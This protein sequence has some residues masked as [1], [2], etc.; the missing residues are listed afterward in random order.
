MDR[1]LNGSDSFLTFRHDDALSQFEAFK[2]EFPL[3]QKS[4]D[5]S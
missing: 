4:E 2:V 5:P 1:V 3:L